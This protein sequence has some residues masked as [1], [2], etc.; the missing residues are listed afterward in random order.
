MVW[1]KWRHKCICIKIS[2]LHP[3]LPFNCT[4]KLFL[5]SSSSTRFY[6]NGKRDRKKDGILDDFSNAGDKVGLSSS[7][8]NY[9]D[10]AFYA[11]NQEEMHLG[12]AS[13]NDNDIA[14]ELNETN[15]PVVFG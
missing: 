15:V 8:L 10:Y 9:N 4:L 7:S 14:P 1:N 2:V 6:Y 3:S 12:C 11:V 13:D 5:N